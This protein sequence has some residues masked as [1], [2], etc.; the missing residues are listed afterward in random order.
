MEQLHP[1][2]DVSKSS[3]E[4]EG[5]KNAVPHETDK[6]LETTLINLTKAVDLF[7]NTN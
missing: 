5:H 4:P 6:I 2:H 7:I 1:A 3:Q